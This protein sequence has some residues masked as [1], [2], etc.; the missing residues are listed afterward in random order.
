MQ[1][2][3]DAEPTMFTVLQAGI[4]LRRRQELQE[5]VATQQARGIGSRGPNHQ[6]CRG[7]RPAHALGTAGAT[8]RT[9]GTIAVAGAAG[10]A[11]TPS[12]APAAPG[13]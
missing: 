3:S 13:G 2:K 8:A 12:V 1:W 5:N 6:G 9:P 10:S 11:A 4:A 7:T